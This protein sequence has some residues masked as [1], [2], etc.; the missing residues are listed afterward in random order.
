MAGSFVARGL[1][2]VRGYRD[3]GRINTSCRRNHCCFCPA[4]A[5]PGV[6][7]E[8]DATLKVFSDPEGNIDFKEFGKVVKK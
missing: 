6:T 8:V 3:S 7:V 4:R 5:K 1:E 2:G